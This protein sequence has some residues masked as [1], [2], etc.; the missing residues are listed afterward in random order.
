MNHLES[1]MQAQIIEWA[2]YRY[3]GLDFL[4]H[5]PNGGKRDIAEAVRFKAEGVRKGFPDLILP[6]RSGNFVGLVIELKVEG[7][8]V[9]DEQRRWLEHFDSQGWRVVV[10]YD[11]ESAIKVLDEYMKGMEDK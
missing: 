8:K 2:T 5:S 9:S 6:T 4:H 10:A 1:D 7:G 11:Y 3:R